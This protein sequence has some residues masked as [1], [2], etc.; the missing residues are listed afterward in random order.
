MKI[1]PMKEQDIPTLLKLYDHARR[2]MVENGNPN[3]WPEWYPSREILQDDIKNGG[4]VI[5]DKNIDDDKAVIIGAFILEENAYEEAYDIIEGQWLNEEPY[6]VIHRCA[7]LH[8]QKGIGQFF[9]DWCFKKASNIRVDTHKDNIPMIKFLEKND[10]TYCGIVH[11]E[12]AGDRLAYQKKYNNS[13]TE[14]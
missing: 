12:N 6:A 13:S 14:F 11:Y 3:Q 7:T 5:L 9:M 1:R 4:Y 8:N 10:F 2:Y